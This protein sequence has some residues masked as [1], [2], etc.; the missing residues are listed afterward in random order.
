MFRVYGGSSVAKV[1]EQ[2]KSLCEIRHIARDFFGSTPLIYHINGTYVL[3]SIL[4][5]TNDS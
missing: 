2:N 5:F 1:C 3:C 4:F